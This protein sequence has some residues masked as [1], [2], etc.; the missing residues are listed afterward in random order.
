[1]KLTPIEFD[2]TGVSAAEAERLHICNAALVRLHGRR[3][4]QIVGERSLPKPKASWKI[5]NYQQAILYRIVTLAS[6]C[7]LNWNNGNTLCS[8]LAARALVETAALFWEFEQ[9]LDELLGCSDIE[10]IDTLINNRTFASKDED[11]LE[12]NP[13]YVATN[14]LTFID[15]IDKKTF[16]GIRKHYDWLSE[17]CHPNSFGHFFF[18]GTLDTDTDTTTF[19]DDKMKSVHLS[20]IIVAMLLVPMIEHSMDHLDATILKVADLQ[21]G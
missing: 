20:N 1:L 8:I 3:K 12:S 21:S 2:K 5:A 15:K 10:G 4:E 11:W 6:G 18:F 13:D 14:I 17:R 7:A 16:P 19:T 9:R